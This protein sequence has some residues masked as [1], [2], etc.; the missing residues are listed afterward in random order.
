MC[1]MFSL[2]QL[3]FNIQLKTLNLKCESNNRNLHYESYYLFLL[4]ENVIAI[5]KKKNHSYDI[6]TI[7]FNQKF[8]TEIEVDR[9]IE[10]YICFTRI[11]YKYITKY[12]IKTKIIQDH[13]T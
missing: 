4:E 12:N 9:Y 1:A 7:S 11:N 2:N 8:Q 13:Q 6:S 10:D 3:I 5:I